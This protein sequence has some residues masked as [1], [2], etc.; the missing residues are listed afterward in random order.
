MHVY[1]LTRAPYAALDGK[2]SL[3][4][5]GRW[6][7]KGNPV[8]YTSSSRALALLE[9]F[10]NL[11]PYQFPSDLVL[12]TIDIPDSLILP[13]HPPNNW[14]SPACAEARAAGDAWINEAAS[15]ALAVPSVVV[16]EESNIILNPSHRSFPLLRVLATRPFH[17][18]PR[19]S[20]A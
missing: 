6:H 1:R 10:V 7:T 16:P 15:A 18:D 19:F 17:P 4:R 12:L 20:V 14:N 13:L 5:S 9:Y 11:S 8:V 3:T 2:G